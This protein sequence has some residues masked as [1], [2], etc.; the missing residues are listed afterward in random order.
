M[1]PLNEQQQLE[2]KQLQQKRERLLTENKIHRVRKDGKNRLIKSYEAAVE[3]MV[4][5]VR[6]LNT[7]INKNFEEYEAA[8][9]QIEQLTGQMPVVI[10]Y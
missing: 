10:Q 7:T 6:D 3:T 1:N 8:G 5:E 9:K 2:L 4:S